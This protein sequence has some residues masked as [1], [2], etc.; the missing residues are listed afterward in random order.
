MRIGVDEHVLVDD[1]RHQ[2]LEPRVEEHGQGADRESNAEHE[3]ACAG[4]G[5]RSD[6]E[7]D[8][9]RSAGEIDPDERRSEVAPPIEDDTG[10]QPEQQHRERLRGGR[11]TEIESL[12]GEGE[13]EVGER[14]EGD[15]VPEEGDRLTPD[16]GHHVASRRTT[17]LH[18][19]GIVDRY[20]AVR[21]HVHG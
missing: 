8:E 5:R 2:R 7:A 11:Q 19:Q 6:G 1:R 15:V 10:D 18:T 13:H 4:A 9:D 16:E 20:L 3:E 12:S 21:S 17:P 14:E